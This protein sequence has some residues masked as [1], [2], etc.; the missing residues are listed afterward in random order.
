MPEDISIAMAV[1]NH[2]ATVA[3]FEGRGVRLYFAKFSE[4]KY[5]TTINNCEA[6]LSILDVMMWNSPKEIMAGLKLGA[7][8]DR[9]W[10]VNETTVR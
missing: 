3:D 10:C 7:K 4:F 1:Y 8:L 9:A 2:E 6:N 5:G